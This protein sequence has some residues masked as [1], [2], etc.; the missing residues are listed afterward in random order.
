MNTTRKS[1]AP[2]FESAGMVVRR[3]WKRWRSDLADWI[4]RNTLPTRKVRITDATPPP[5]PGTAKP[6]LVPHTIMKSK[7]FQPSRK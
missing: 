3:V 4:S 5:A 2:M 6:R 7:R 1:S